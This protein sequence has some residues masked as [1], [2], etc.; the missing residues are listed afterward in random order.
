MQELLVFPYTQFHAAY[1]LVWQ[2]CV[3][4]SILGLLICVVPALQ[5]FL[6]V[7]S[8]YINFTLYCIAIYLHPLLC[9]NHYL[10]T[11]V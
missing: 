4:V 7:S 10:H 6:V 2:V 11:C 8:D 5:Q 3:C 1:Y 9:F